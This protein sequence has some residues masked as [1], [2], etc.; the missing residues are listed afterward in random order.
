MTDFM[1]KREEIAKVLAGKSICRDGSL[2]FSCPKAELSLKADECG[3]G[4]FTITGQEG[5]PLLGTVVTEDIRMQCLTPVYK[6]SPAEIRYRFD[7]TGLAEGEC[8][9]GEFKVISNQG[10]YTLPYMIHIVP[11]IFETSMGQMKN[12]FHFTNLAK[13]NWAEAVRTFYRPGFEKILTGNDRQYINIYR[14]LRTMPEQEQRVE[15]FLIGVRKKQRVEYIA[16][17]DSLMLFAEEGI[18]TERITL[19]RNGWGYTRLTI[20]TEGDFLQTEKTALTDDDFLGN[21]C[22]I[23]VLID[24]SRLHAGSNYG[25]IHIYNEY[26]SLEIPICVRQHDAMFGRYRKNRKNQIYQFFRIYLQYCTGKISKQTWLKQTEEIVESMDSRG[27][28]NPVKELIQAHVLITRER[29][30]EAK[31]ILEK[32]ENLIVPMKTRE[33]VWSYYRYLTTLLH[34]DEEYTKS[35]TEEVRHI[36]YNNPTNWEIA[37]L[38]LYLDEEYSSLSKRWVFLEQQFEK[39]C[40]SPIW[41]MEA[42]M[43]ARK[44][45]AVLMKLTPFVMQTLNFMTKYDYLTDECIGQIH[46]LAGRTKNYSKQM[47]SIL[48]NCYKKKNDLESLRAICALLI[49][50]GKTGPEYTVWY[51]EG[52]CRE[53]WLTRLYEYYLLSIDMEHQEEI[54]TAA[55]RYFS[56]KSELPY[57]RMAYLYAYVVKKCEDYP[58]IYRSY[59]PD[60]ERFLVK[61]LEKGRMNRDIGCLY[62]KLIQEEIVGADLIGRFAK[63]LFIQEIKIFLKDIRYVIVVHGKLKEETICPVI[64]SSAYVPLYDS[65]YSLIFESRS[66]HRFVNEDDYMKKTV[67]YPEEMIAEILPEDAGVLNG[68]I[69]VLLYQCEHGRV[70]TTVNGDNIRYARLLWKS[71]AIR[72]SYKKELQIKLLQYYME[73]DSNE[74]L[75][76]FLEELQP[77]S[78]EE[79]NRTEVLRCMILRGM[80]EKA[81]EWIRSY[82]AERLAPKLIFRLCSRI[83]QNREDTSVCMTALAYQA[84][85]AEKYDEILLRYLAKNYLGT[86]R[87]MRKIWHACDRFAVSCYELNERLLLQMLFTG[88]HMDEETDVFIR[89]LEGSADE[90]LKNACLEHFAYGYFMSRHKLDEKIWRELLRKSRDGEYQSSMCKLAVLEYLSEKEYPDEEESRVIR[91]LL[92]E[93]ILKQGFMFSFFRKFSKIVPQVAYYDN[94]T[95]LEYRTQSEYPMILHYMLKTDGKGGEYRTEEIKSCYPGIYTRNFPVF[96]GETIEYYISEKRGENERLVANGTLGKS[97]AGM[98][99]SKERFHMINDYIV[100][101]SLQDKEKAERA[102]DSYYRTEFSAEKLF[103]L[104]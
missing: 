94:Q 22:L 68:E 36:Y 28:A 45:P 11:E 91:R 55:L 92:I 76:A 97:E 71:D 31:W 49:K 60:M 13:I 48:Q 87:E 16:D 58:D 80:Y 3:E 39:G 34:N 51:R 50:G 57:D 104:L 37:W 77:H 9:R 84:F 8:A 2:S 44:N 90:D 83:L 54:P 70:Y 73:Q 38:L 52:I 100:A 59:L 6:E 85:H 62:R 35:V 56:Y 24:G 42:A 1:E 67:S 43:L 78:V 23:M 17:K 7:S 66:G 82:G 19:T 41:Y 79:R 27:R 93:L 98:E 72:S 12:L 30:N 81:Y 63:S 101:V 64:G 53:L 14:A 5:L 32:A 10:E 26:I 61:Q 95:F 25:K 20:E 96:F 69:G 46:Y 74:E 99:A 18:S 4:S 47:L 88:E 103:T 65:D 75:D 29:Y 40:R 15:E 89:Y 102:L 86:M 33:D 21:R